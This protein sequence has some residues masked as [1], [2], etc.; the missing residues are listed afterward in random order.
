MCKSTF[1]PKVSNQIYCSKDCSHKFFDNLRKERLKNSPH[2]NKKCKRCS[3]SFIITGGNNQYCSLYCQNENQK[4]IVNE[5]YHKNKILKGGFREERGCVECGLIFMAV[6]ARNRFCSEECKNKNQY[7]RRKE[8]GERSYDGEYMRNYHKKRRD[9][10][11][12]FNMMGRIRHRTREAIKRGGFTKRSKTYEILGCDWETLKEHIENKFVDGMSWENMKEWDLDHI[13]PLSWCSSIEELE[14]YSHYS[15]L[16][17]LW[18]KD[19]QDK[20]DK[21]IG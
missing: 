11:P 17:P 14:I 20:K 6:N 1:A 8:R 7:S 15:N 16:Q 5:A 13:Y 2:R 10:D 3:K 12:K 9:N 19:N 21:Y 18:R 4:K